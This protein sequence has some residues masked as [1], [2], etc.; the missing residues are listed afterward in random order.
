MQDLL[1][2]FKQ[3]IENLQKTDGKGLDESYY[4]VNSDKERELV[5]IYKQLIKYTTGCD[6]RKVFV[7]TVDDEG[8]IRPIFIDTAKD[9]DSLKECCV[10]D[11]DPAMVGR[12]PYK[13]EEKILLRQNVVSITTHKPNPDYVCWPDISGRWCCVKV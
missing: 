8:K 3:K 2:S 5:E 12:N 1:E 13:E 4:C 10:S 6:F 7:M 11:S 9:S